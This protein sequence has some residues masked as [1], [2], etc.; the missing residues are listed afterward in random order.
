MKFVIFAKLGTLYFGRNSVFVF[1]RIVS[2]EQIR[3]VSLYSSA[4]DVCGRLH[5]VSAQMLLLRQPDFGRRWT[6]EGERV[7]ARQHAQ[8]AAIIQTSRRI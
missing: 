3:I 4:N 2:S 5:S 6:N 1:G 8:Q 7:M